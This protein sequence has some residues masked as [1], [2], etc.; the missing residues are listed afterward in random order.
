MTGKETPKEKAF[1]LIFHK[2]LNERSLKDKVDSALLAAQTV[3]GTLSYMNA[4]PDGPLHQILQYWQQVY[5]EILDVEPEDY[6]EPVDKQ[7]PKEE[8]AERVL[9]S[10]RIVNVGRDAIQKKSELNIIK[11]R[12]K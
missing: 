12:R 11:Y 1:S 8:L 2:S 6:I 10:S 9:E 3:I 5:S 7:E 4:I